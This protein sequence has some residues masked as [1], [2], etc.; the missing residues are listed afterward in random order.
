MLHMTSALS[1]LP[2]VERIRAFD[3]LRGYFLIV[4]LFNHLYYY[5]SGLDFITGRGDLYASSAEGFFIISG[6]VLG[7]VRGQKLI[8]KPFSIGAKLLLKR[9]AQLYVTSVIL[10]IVFTLIA[11]IFID[12]PGVKNSPLPPGTPF[13]EVVWKAATYQY[14]YGW[15][16]FLRQ[17]AIF[18]AVAPIALWLLRRGLWYIVMAISFAVWA[19]FPHL[20]GSGFMLQPIA[21]Q[22]VFFSGFV[23]G[24]H[25]PQ[26]HDLWKRLS[27]KNR[28]LIGNSLAATAIA[29]IIASA[30]VVFGYKFGGDIGSTLL[31]WHRSIEDYFYKDRLPLQRLALGAVWFWGLFYL[32]RRNEAWLT[33]KIG[34]LLN[35]LGVNSLYVY[36]LQAFLVFFTHLFIVP[37]QAGN[38]TLPWYVNLFISLALLT[39]IWVAVKREFLFKIIPR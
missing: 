17:Y 10:A 26:L 9:S 5:P 38:P 2:R 27:L 7:I 34:W 24:F 18:I 36:T 39:L 31:G 29:T 6:I 12:N 30:L 23:I 33:D 16:D 22:F 25:W 20:D 13:W 35:P 1:G 32:V 14:L 21:W 19:L 37:T 15:A 11:W 28:R 4:I 3:L 8:A